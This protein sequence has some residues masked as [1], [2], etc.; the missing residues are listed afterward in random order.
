MRFMRICGGSL[1]SY[2]DAVVRGGETNNESL[3]H[4]YVGDEPETMYR[5]A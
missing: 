2:V 5:S 3:R 1:F 4:L